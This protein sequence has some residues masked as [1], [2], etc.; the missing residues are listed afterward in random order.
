[1]G[2]LV[3]AEFRKIFTTNLWWGLLIPT[4]LLGVLW[5][6]GF[7]AFGS[8]VVERLTSTPALE[9]VDAGDWMVSVFGFA[10]GAN[11]TTLFPMIFGAL[12]VAGENYRR[13]ITTTFLTASSR[14]SALGAKLV[15]YTVV[16]LGFGVA[17]ALSASLGTVL[18]A[19][20]TPL[21]GGAGWFLLTLT[22]ILESTLWTLFGVGV[23]ALVGN[24]FGAVIGLL[25]YAVLVENLGAYVLSSALETTVPTVLP[26]GAAS[27]MPGAVAADLFLD[28][29]GPINPLVEKEARLVVEA[30]AGAQGAFPWWA[31]TLIFA[32]YTALF[33]CLGWLVTG[34]RDI[35]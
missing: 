13:T 28:K 7:S 24:I 27:G 32:G 9:G 34:R 26:N 3:R 30:A 21:P 16:G 33:I 2:S 10:R 8:A 22:T 11:L 31:N 6:W 29:V 25:I 15:V 12:A 35:S 19:G 1:M 14:G 17:V 4:V 20:N 18:G 5:S 23:G